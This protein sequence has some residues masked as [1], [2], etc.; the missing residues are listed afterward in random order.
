MRKILIALLAL[1]AMALAEAPATYYSRCEGLGGE[2]L[3]QALEQ[4]VGPHTNVGYS[5]LWTLYGK[6]DVYPDG[7]IWDMY[8]TKHWTVGGEQCGT[9][10]SVGDCYNREHSMPKSWFDDA[11][12]MYSDAFH[13]YPTDGKVNGQRG[14]YPY[15]ECAYG[16]TLSGSGSVKALGRLGA[17]TFPGYSGTVFEPADEYKGDFARSYFY[18]AACYNSLID[19]WHSDMLAGNSYPAFTGWAVDLLLKWHRQ[20]P[21]SSKELDRQE[22][23]YAAQHN[24]NP[25]IDHPEMAEYI[26]GNKK[27]QNWSAGG[28]RPASI[29]IPA[30]G[31]V[32]DYGYITLGQEKTITIRV[33]GTNLTAPVTL[34]C[35]SLEVTADRS[36]ISAA[37]ANQPDGVS[38]AVTYAPEEAGECD[39][40]LRFVSGSTHSTVR[41]IGQAVGHVTAGAAEDVTDCSFVATWTYG[42]DEMDGG[43]YVLH[44]NDLAIN[45]DA[46]DGSHYVDGL[47]PST[48]YEYWVESKNFMSNV[49][50]FTTSAPIPSVDLL[51]DGDLYL[52]AAPGE[53]S[54]AYEL[55]VDVD[56]IDC[57]IMLAV[58][59]PFSLSSDKAQWSTSLTISPEEDRVYIR[60][61]ADRAGRYS[62]SVI[63]T[64]GDYVNDDIEIWGSVSEDKGFIEDFEADASGCDTYSGCDFFGAA[65]EWHLSNAGIWAADASSARSGKQCVRMGKNADSFIEMRSDK[66]HGLGTVTLWAERWTANDGDCELCIDYSTDGGKTWQSTTTAT[67]NSDD[68]QMLTFTVN[69]PGEGRIRIRQTAGKRFIIDDVAISDFAASG[70]DG[71][72]SDYRSWDAFCRGGE[73][74]IE[75]VAEQSVRVYGVDGI[76]RH[77]GPMPTGSTALALPQGLYIISVADFSR[78]VLVK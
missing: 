32:Y 24:R 51:Y 47:E 38:V 55:L 42:G 36:T 58:K 41:L 10:Q 76:I 18:M 49:V 67:V 45:V 8:S 11:A 64:A 31:A 74:I 53:P 15:G 17:S 48:Q 16:S 57:P 52:E 35:T 27:T 43:K 40:E 25:F 29:D 3:L 69:Q 78:R 1:P 46:R 21:V 7:K 6:S 26:W 2:Q 63:I 5:G 12:P 77:D 39:A 56:N 33:K 61:Y 75:L 62:T 59:E 73:L 19:D 68:Y 14:N 9:Y 22:A 28:E 20:D 13:I 4:V 23:V 37:E 50:R 44:V 70:L 71:V 54:Q 60:I 72:E 30:D 34:T 65:S 66:G